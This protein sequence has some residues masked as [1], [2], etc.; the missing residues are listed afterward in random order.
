[1]SRKLGRDEMK[2]HEIG[3][4]N[5]PIAKSL[6]IIGDRWTLL[7]IRNAFAGTSRFEDFQEQLGITRHLLTERIKRLVES[8]IFEKKLYCDAPKRYEYK[9]TEKGLAL[10]PILKSLSIWGKVWYD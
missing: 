1:M 10:Q 5:C 4:L 7:I 8:D 6:S 2:W 3:K 9:L